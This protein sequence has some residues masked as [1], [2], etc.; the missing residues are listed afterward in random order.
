MA[1]DFSLGGG[2]L[3][4]LQIRHRQRHRGPRRTFRQERRTQD[5]QHKSNDSRQQQPTTEQADQ[6][7]RQGSVQ[8]L[9]VLLRRKPC[10][11]EGIQGHGRAGTPA[12]PLRLY[13]MTMMDQLPVSPLKPADMP[14]LPVL[15]GLRVATGN[16]GTR[17]Q[18]RADVTLFVLPEQTSAAGVFT[19][20]KCPSAPV[21]WC[22]AVLQGSAAIAGSAAGTTARALLINAGNANAFTGAV[23]AQACA[24]TASAVAGALGC[25]PEAVLLSSTGVIG[26]PLE[27]EAI[28]D[29]AVQLVGDAEEASLEAAAAAIATTDTFAKWAQA[30]ATC[31][32]GH[33]VSVVGIAKGSGMIAPDMAT[34]LGYVF[35]DAAVEADWLQS[36]LSRAADQTFNAMTVDSDTSTSDTV[37]AFGLGSGAAVSTDADLQAVEAAIFSVCDQLAEQIARDGEGASKLITITVEGA[38]SAA[39]ARTIGLSIAN[40]PLV[41]TAIAGEDANWGRVVMAVGKAGEAADR[42]RLAIWFGPHQV[43][44]GGLRDPGY[45]EDAV[46][47]YMTAAEIDIRVDLGLGDG[48]ARVRTCDLT[49]GYISINADYRS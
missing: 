44:S 46:S 19:R 49:H 40:S 25:A 6:S 32:D 1:A 29:A 13:R 34:M 16:S 26:E 42:D 35:V 24:H 41:K 22:R 39:A 38:E 11:P 5:Q 14:A 28:A 15:K 43:A 45:S 33:A 27:A 37:L 48:T 21:D 7:L 20:S 17:Y 36:V 31:T 18:G 10:F 47:G 9:A 12:P 4:R 30:E 3:Q 8:H 23:G 2:L